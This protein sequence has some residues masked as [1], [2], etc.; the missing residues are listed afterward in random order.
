MRCKYVRRRDTKAERYTVYL[1]WWGK[2][3]VRTSYLDG[4]PL[5]CKEMAD[6]LCHVVNADI[7]D[8]RQMG[9]DF[10]PRKWFKVKLSELRFQN[11][12]RAWLDKITLRP[13]SFGVY[14][15]VVEGACEVMGSVDVREIGRRHLKK[16]VESISRLNPNTQAHHLGVLKGLFNYAYREG[17]IE[18]VPAFP[19]IKRREV[20]RASLEEQDVQH[21][22]SCVPEHDHPIFEFMAYYGL[23]VSEA[24]AL[25]WD[26]VLWSRQR[27]IIKRTMSANVVRM[28]RKAGD[29]LELP[30]TL[31]AENILRPLRQFSGFVFLNA[32][33]RRYQ[34]QHLLN[35]CYKACALAGYE[36]VSLHELCRH[37]RAGQLKSRGATLEQIGALLGHKSPQTTR[38]Y[39]KVSTRAINR[40]LTDARKIHEQ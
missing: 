33:G 19:K 20:L 14:R 25:Q 30:L 10:D 31:E 5:G 38:K 18:K 21:I 36:R 11:Y 2:Q 1:Y 7:D 40:L 26:A 6:R 29:V 22:I 27:V 12:A 35:L 37:S 24:I 39:G 17:D 28:F 23:R 3:W 9:I 4:L 16:Y 13:S 8:C 34:R 32:H 15:P